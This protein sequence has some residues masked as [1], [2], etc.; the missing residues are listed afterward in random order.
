M[1]EAL[2]S[3]AFKNQVETALNMGEKIKQFLLF[4]LFYS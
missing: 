2:K 4:L 3:L 1:A